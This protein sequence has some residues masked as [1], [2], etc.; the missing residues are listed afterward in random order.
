MLR[1]EQCR[2][3]RVATRALVFGVVGTILRQ[4][5][6]GVKSNPWIEAREIDG[7]A[8]ALL[9]PIGM[10]NLGRTTTFITIAM[11]AITALAALEA[12]VFAQE[13][14]NGPTNLYPENLSTINGHPIKVGEH[15]EYYNQH[16][17]FSV[18]LNPL[19]LIMGL[20][21]LSGTYAVSD[22]VGVRGEFLLIRKAFG[23]GGANGVSLQGGVPI[24]FKQ[25]YQ[26]FFLEPGFTIRGLEQNGVTAGPHVM[27]G[28]QWR[29]D[30]GFTAAM[31]F[32][33]GRDFGNNDEVFPTGYFHT[34]YTF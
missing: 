32:G 12:P 34:G 29:W 1:S 2:V 3:V 8:R 28:W 5:F 22:H 26:G 17:K 14:T 15:N 7:V 20:Y 23:D 24:F 6:Q 4:Q 27:A 9:F 11:S 19:G 33:A 30:S 18:G 31:A 16:P 25:M 21:G 10:N 13:R